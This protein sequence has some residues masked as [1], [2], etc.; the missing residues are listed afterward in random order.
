[1]NSGP[2]YQKSFAFALDAVQ[3]YK[4]LVS[5][6]EFIISKQF[7]RSAT[8]IGANVCE[9]S[10]GHSPK[11]FIYKMSIASKEARE[12][13]YWLRLLRESKLTAIPLSSHLEKVSELIK[14][15]T[16]IIKTSQEKLN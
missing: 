16:S 14:L 15:L 1:M 4:Q 2:I 5:E 12:T 9:A 6:K 3:L 7:L 13:F 10:A 11:D 8:S